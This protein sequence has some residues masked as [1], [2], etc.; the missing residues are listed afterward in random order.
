MVRNCTMNHILY[1]FA[2][3]RRLRALDPRAQLIA[4]LRGGAVTIPASA[5]SPATAAALRVRTEHPLGL[6][7]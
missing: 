6:A 4:L 1:L 5:A 2:E 7:A 3:P